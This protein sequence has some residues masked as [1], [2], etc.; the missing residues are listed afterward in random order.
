MIDASAA[1][2]RGFGVA[3]LTDEH[4]VGVGAEDRTQRVRER[5]PDARVDLDLLD[6]VEPVLD[7]VL[8]RDDALDRVLTSDST[9]VHR[10]R[11]AGTGRAGDEHRALRCEERGARSAPS[12]RGVEPEARRGRARR[13]IGSRRRRITDSPAAVGMVT[14]RTSTGRPCDGEREPAVLREAVLRDVEV[15][16]DLQ[17]AD[18]RAQ[19]R[20][21]HVGGVVEHAVDRGTGSRRGSSRARRAGRRPGR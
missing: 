13:A 15:R 3:H 17:P 14:T 1:M 6:A 2:R 9:R 21:R 20:E 11:L 16:H 8:H 18:Q 5:E 12:P 19:Q 4:D 7:R 10:R